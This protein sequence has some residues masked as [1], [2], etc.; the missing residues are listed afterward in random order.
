MHTLG[1]SNSVYLYKCYLHCSPSASAL[2]KARYFTTCACYIQAK[3]S[4]GHHS[5]IQH[6]CSLVYICVYVGTCYTE[7]VH[8][9]CLCLGVRSIVKS[10]YC[11]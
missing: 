4:E 1:F 3:C 11:K 10:I 9:V 7:S 8:D 6:Y 5:G 2:L